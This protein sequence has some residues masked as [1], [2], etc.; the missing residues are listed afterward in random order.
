VNGKLRRWTY[1][2]KMVAPPEDAYVENGNWYTAD[3]M[4]IGLYWEGFVIIQQ[5]YNDPSSGAHGILYKSPVG[6]GLGLY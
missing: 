3:G 2:I 6:P 1:F 5:V 4:E